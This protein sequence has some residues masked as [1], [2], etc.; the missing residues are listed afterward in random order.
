MIEPSHDTS[1]ESNFGHLLIERNGSWEWNYNMASK[2]KFTNLTVI[3]LL[4][5]HFPESIAFMK[6]HAHEIDHKKHSGLTS[7]MIACRYYN[8]HSS[9]CCVK[10]LIDLDA[11][12]YSRDDCGNDALMHA[13]YN[14]RISKS[15]ECIDLLIR[16]MR[17]YNMDT[18]NKYGQ[19][20]LM[21]ACDIK[22][23]RISSEVVRMLLQH[24]KIVN[25]QHENGHSS[26]IIACRKQ[27][28]KVVKLLLD[29]GASVNVQCENGQTALMIA[30]RKQNMKI[31]KLL[32]NTD[33]N[34]NLQNEH[35]QTALM[36]A[37]KNNQR[38]IILLLLNSSADTNL[39]SNNGN[40]ALMHFCKHCE[41][42]ES[43]DKIL[44]TLING[45]DNVT[46]TNLNNKTSYHY[47]NENPK[48]FAVNNSDY[49]GSLLND[50][51]KINNVK[52]SRNT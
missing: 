47:F 50:E 28:I 2:K 14:C 34:V 45:I 17:Y 16:H 43:D 20:A 52:S 40:T 42:V 8:K 35:G 36:L 3:V 26:L 22:N 33:A 11:D 39:K 27:N 37:C 19:T 9:L 46:G 7:I 24:R 31:V 12:L 32:L 13:I 51:T 44:L 18:K 30:C 21:I 29:A 48:H 23:A 41:F 38:E 6:N 4:T 49:I 1:V 10:L 15:T 5:K 25:L